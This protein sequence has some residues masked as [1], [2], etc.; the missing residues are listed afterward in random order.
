MV[1]E[2]AAAYLSYERVYAH[3]WS[4]WWLLYISRSWNVPRPKIILESP[5]P[6]PVTVLDHSL[7]PNRYIGKKV[8]HRHC[9]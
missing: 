3:I 1:V 9:H 2:R 7:S 8:P 4:Q 5:D 6:A